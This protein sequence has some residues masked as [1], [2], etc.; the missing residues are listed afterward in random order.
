MDFKFKVIGLGKI[1]DTERNFTVGEVYKVKNGTVVSDA[2]YSY[3]AWSRN[4]CTFENLQRWFD[5]WYV[6]ELVTDDSMTTPDPVNHPSHYCQDGSMEAI[7]EMIA[8]FGVEAVKNFCLLNVWKYRK[9][10]I[11]KNGEE[12]LKKSDWYMNKYVE[13]NGRG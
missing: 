7:D 10:A 3:S 13:L 4:E 9:R 12:D 2:N 5:N 8:V 11:F 1:V 6:F